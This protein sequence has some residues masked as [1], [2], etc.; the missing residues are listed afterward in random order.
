MIAKLVLSTNWGLNNWSGYS[1]F[2]PCFD[3]LIIWY[4]VYYFMKFG[5]MPISMT[6]CH[7]YT[8]NF[9]SSRN[10]KDLYNA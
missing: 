7:F 2:E 1:C 10:D 5:S 6:E 8:E 9:F 4:Y 3:I